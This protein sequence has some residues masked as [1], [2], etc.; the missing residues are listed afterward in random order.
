VS[1]WTNLADEEFCYLTTRGRVSGRPHRIEIWFALDDATLYLLSGGRDRSDWVKNL[2][3]TPEATVELGPRRFSGR[4]RIVEDAA[5]EE[6]ARALV[7]DKYAQG[8]GGDLTSWRRTAL[9]VAVDLRDEI[10][11]TQGGSR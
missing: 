11:T 6:R 3:A 2:R 10:K 9:L 8:H 1:A 4:A 5:E 7:H